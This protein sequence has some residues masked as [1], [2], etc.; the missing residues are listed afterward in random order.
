MKAVIYDSHKHYYM[1]ASVEYVIVSIPFTGCDLGLQASGSNHLHVMQVGY[2]NNNIYMSR[3]SRVQPYYTR[4]NYA[5]WNLHDAVQDNI[6]DGLPFHSP[7]FITHNTNIAYTVN[8][9]LNN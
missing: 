7:P 6:S 1:H 8:A 4:T 3:T 5:Q 9:L 2:S